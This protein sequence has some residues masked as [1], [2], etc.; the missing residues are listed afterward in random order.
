[1]LSQLK[2][3][4]INHAGWVTGVALVTYAAA[5]LYLGRMDQVSAWADVVAGLGLLGLHFKNQ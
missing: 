5:G 4:A 2:D 1:M 3:A